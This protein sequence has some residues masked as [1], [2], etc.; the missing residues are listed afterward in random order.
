MATMYS[1]RLGRVIA[2][3]LKHRKP[4]L[5][6]SFRWGGIVKTPVG[7]RGNPVHWHLPGDGKIFAGRGRQDAA[8]RQQRNRL[9]RAL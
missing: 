2:D 8:T 9:E 6:I 1:R 7:R 5:L 3:P 4:L